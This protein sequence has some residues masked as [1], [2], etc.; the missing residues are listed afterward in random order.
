MSSLVIDLII[1]A[2]LVIG[3]GF[4]LIGLIGLLLFPDTRSRMYTA[5]RATMISLGSVGLAV[6]IYGLYA[7][8]TAGGNQYVTLLLHTL[9][10][11]VVIAL[12]NYVVS[13]NILEKTRSIIGN[14]APKEKNR[15]GRDN[16]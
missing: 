9:M 2:L 5:V 6:F 13:S 10:L 14:P 1:W 15:N 12:G 3:V 7:L 4:G 16:K 11:V 8:R